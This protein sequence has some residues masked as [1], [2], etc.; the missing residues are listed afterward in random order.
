M[1]ELVRV[2][3][4]TPVAE[5]VLSGSYLVK[6]PVGL[7]AGNWRIEV[8]NLAVEGI[9]TIYHRRTNYT[10]LTYHEAMI[11]GA[12][13]GSTTVEN[14]ET[15]LPPGGTPGLSFLGLND[16]G[17]GLEWRTAAGA[18][19]MTVAI[20]DPQMIFDDA[21]DRANHTGTQDVGTIT[22]LGDLAVLDTIGVELIDASGTPSGTTFL[23]GDGVWATPPGGG[24]TGDM[25]A[26]TY[27]PQN[28]A[29]DAFDRANHTGTQLA[30]TISDL[31]NLAVLDEITVSL[32][33]ATGTP[34][35]T[36]FLRG[37]G[38]WAVPAGSG[39]GDMEAATYDPQNI[40]DDAFDRAN[41]TGTQLAAT[42]SDLGNLAVLDEITV[43]LID[44]T[45]TPDNT[46]F[47][48]GDGAWATP[49]TPSGVVEDADYNAHTILAAVSDN[50]PVAL[51]VAEQ[52]LVGRI[53]GGNIDDLSA[54]DVR[55]LLQ[56]A[57]GDSPQLA[58]LNLGH[59]SDTTLERLSAGLLGVEGQAVA[60]RDI[61][62]VNTTASDIAD[63]TMIGKIIEM[64]VGSANTFTIPPNSSVA[65]PVG[66]I[67]NVIQY[68]AGT[69]SIVADTG[70][71]LNGVSTGEAEISERYQGVTLY[72]R[73]T[74]EWVMSGA[75]GTVA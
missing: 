69:T 21:F 70:V 19:D 6:D 15:E 27:D 53:T 56:L 13:V 74:D 17:D 71:T 9:R 30:A 11:K 5:L 68:G 61:A 37:D 7:P 18:G 40:A 62:P 60:F 36:T 43:S 63:L 38:A 42:I 12:S 1:S 26:A 58:G 73:A 14:A 52:T 54:S 25:E 45:G 4:N 8:E 49:P 47:L 64:N 29:D 72:K 48:R 66:T 44:A 22:G 24:G 3:D 55:T 50:T 28:I 46:T 20:Y 16:A 31:G 10:E 51:T 41:H 23:R 67:I 75:H 35:G 32:I 65:F 34:D 39:S 2:P 33:D 59:A 57:T